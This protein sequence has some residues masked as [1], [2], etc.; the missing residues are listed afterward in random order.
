MA[1]QP[2]LGVKPN[3]VQDYKD[4]FTAARGCAAVE[5]FQLCDAIKQSKQL[6]VACIIRRL[7]FDWCDQRQVTNMTTIRVI[8]GHHQHSL[9][10]SYVHLHHMY[11]NGCGRSWHSHDKTYS[12]IVK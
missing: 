1:S 12:L 9:A 2:Q 10:M 7:L 5:W 4:V 8:I 6:V 3:D 11:P